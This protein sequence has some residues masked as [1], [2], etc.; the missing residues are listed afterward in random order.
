VVYPT[1]GI[2]TTEKRDE[3]PAYAPVGVWPATPLIS[4]PHLFLTRAY[5]L[6]NLK[7]QAW[8]VLLSL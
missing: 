5:S 2:T 8:T 1:T 6:H 4:L 7:L 3:H